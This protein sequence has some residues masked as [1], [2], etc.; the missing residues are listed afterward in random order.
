MNKKNSIAPGAGGNGDGVRED[1]SKNERRKRGAPEEGAGFS[2][3]D[4]I[5]GTGLASVAVSATV[6]LGDEV[7]KAAGRAQGGGKWVGPEPVEVTLR[8]NGQERKLQVEPRVTLLDALR[9]RLDL[10]G[11]KKVCDRATCGA[12]T[13]IIDGKAH[14]SCTTLA[15]DAQGHDILTIEGIGSEDKLHPVSQA[16][17]DNDAQQCGFCT[18]GFVMASKAYLDHEP[19]PTYEGVQKALGGNLCRCGTYMGIRHAALEAAK[20][21][22]RA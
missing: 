7:A 14:Y 16:F 12:C 5:K 19:S 6:L 20:K 2:R 13:V 22:G 18:P 21:G 15:I 17:V 9:N 1:A 10:T 11:A 4:F 3:R 8:I